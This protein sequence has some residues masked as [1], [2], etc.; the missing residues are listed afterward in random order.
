MDSALDQ[1]QS[2]VTLRAARRLSDAA[3]FQISRKTRKTRRVTPAGLKDL[4]CNSCHARVRFCPDHLKNSGKVE[5]HAYFGLSSGSTHVDGCRYTVTRAVQILA[6]ES[7]AATGHEVF[8]QDGATHRYRLNL[9]TVALGEANDLHKTAV[10]SGESAVAVRYAHRADIARLDPYI[11]TATAVA[12]LYQRVEEENDREHLR[13]AITIVN[14]QIIVPWREFCYDEDQWRH[15]YDRLSRGRITH[16]VAIVG[17]FGDVVRSGNALSA[18]RRTEPHQYRGRRIRIAIYA[19]D[20]R[21]L[22]RARSGRKVVVVGQPWANKF[23][24][25]NENTICFT[26]VATSQISSVAF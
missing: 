1:S 8:V 4:R 13:N 14:D 2:E 19:L 17:T 22:K 11:Q 15:L 16:P 10:S 7:N 5:V 20:G 3:D 12:R 9:V 25:N 23:D 21:L 24:N 18:R 26:V 6:A